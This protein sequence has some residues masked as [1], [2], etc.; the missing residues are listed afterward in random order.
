[1]K[2]AAILNGSSPRF[3]AKA[4][5]MHAFIEANLKEAG[6]AV[7][8]VVH[9][10]SAGVEELKKNL[11]SARSVLIKLAQS[12]PETALAVLPDLCRE[13]DLILF[14][15]DFFG[16]EM[17]IRLGFRLGGSSL[18]SVLSL[19]CRPDKLFCEKMVYSQHLKAGFELL[20]KPYCL[21]LAKG[22][23]EAEFT[24]PA[25]QEILEMG[26]YTAEKYLPW[27]ISRE[28]KEAEESA[29]LNEACHLLVAGRGAG[30]EGVE[31][32]ARLAE[33]LKIQW[34]VT[35][36]VALNAWAPLNRLV[37]VSG[38]MTKP[39]LT[40]VLGASGAAAFYA[41]I[42]KSK[43]IISVNRDAG[44]AM[45]RQSDAVAIDDSLAVLTELLKLVER[46]D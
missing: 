36:P 31:K 2:I 10:E 26:D 40:L 38:A 43:I 29:G 6:T 4:R 7:S 30:S 28:F 27:L 23:A 37:G 11:F 13:H 44:A 1:M 14:S 9:D 25:N 46:R 12:E 32:V 19:D 18:V 24:P 34:G 17:A 5:Q 39:E 15:D 16:E 45:T 35:R 22:G 20:K 21:S 41:G 8:I 42:E 33:A 3:P